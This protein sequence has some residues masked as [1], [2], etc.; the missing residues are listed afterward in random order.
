M[1]AVSQSGHALQHAAEATVSGE[2]D[3]AWMNIWLDINDPT[4]IDENGA[5]ACPVEG[6]CICYPL[7]SMGLSIDPASWIKSMSLQ[8]QVA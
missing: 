4:H 2:L 7:P 5:D 6:N 3:F 8:L 1:T